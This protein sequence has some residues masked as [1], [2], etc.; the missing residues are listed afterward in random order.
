M[1]IVDFHTLQAV[2]TLHLTQQ[3]VLNGTHA[4]DLQNIMR[5]YRTFCQLITC[6]KQCTVHN[7]DT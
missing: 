3:V 2:Y 4:F 5:I 7:L 1:L 6:F